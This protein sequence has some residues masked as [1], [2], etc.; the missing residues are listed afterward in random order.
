MLLGTMAMPRSQLIENK[1]VATEEDNDGVDLT[2]L[3]PG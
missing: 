1:N 2:L 3:P